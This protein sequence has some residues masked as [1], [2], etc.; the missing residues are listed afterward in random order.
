MSKKALTNFDICINI[1]M[2]TE[3]KQNYTVNNMYNKRKK[4]KRLNVDEFMSKTSKVPTYLK[5]FDFLKSAIK[6][7]IEDMD[8]PVY[9]IQETISEEYQVTLSSVQ[10][11]IRTAVDKSMGNIDGDMKE[12]I[13]SG[14]DV[15][16]AKYI[17]SVAYAIK[18]NII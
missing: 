11:G 1:I 3:N 16:A 10:R 13:F 4:V 15:T 6:L 18:N 9:E 8:K 12:K 7:Q 14:Y 5:G 2:K 17:K